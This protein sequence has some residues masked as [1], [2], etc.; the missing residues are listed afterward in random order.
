MIY[1]GQ[2]G[3]FMEDRIV[4]T[5]AGSKTR[6]RKL[7]HVVQL[8]HIDEAVFD[9]QVAKSKRF[10]SPFDACR[11]ATIMKEDGSTTLSFAGTA[12]CKMED[13]DDIWGDDVL[14]S[15]NFQD[16]D[17]KLEKASSA[18]RRTGRKSKAKK[19]Y[20]S[21]HTRLLIHLEQLDCEGFQ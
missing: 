7:K 8:G 12:R 3:K 14:P 21:V 6:S 2:M 5:V 20:P 16:D 17:P 11:V 15:V 4:G 10:S 1:D 18:G 9:G 13:G 19:I